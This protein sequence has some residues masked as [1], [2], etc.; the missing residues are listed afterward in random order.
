MR[1]RTFVA[2]LGGTAVWSLAARGQSSPVKR[3][4]MLLP[5]AETDPEAQRRIAAFREGMEK[6]GWK[7]GRNVQFEYRWTR[8]SN[9]QPFAE[10]LVSLE[11][12]VILANSTPP[13]KALQRATRTVP[14]VFVAV[15][16]PLGDGLV[17]SLA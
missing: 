1:R 2:V 11:P 3:L 9:P 17:A 7:E 12:D 13:V 14:V 4:G 6:L 8:A 16:D 10:Q 15:S 5:F